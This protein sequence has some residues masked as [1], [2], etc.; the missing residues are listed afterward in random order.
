M[1]ITIKEYLADPAFFLKLSGGEH[2]I[3]VMD[4]S[5]VIAVLG[6]G[7]LPPVTEEERKAMEEI[8]NLPDQKDDGCRTTWFD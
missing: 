2:Q 1:R 4:G 8:D 6:W 3:Q 5:K 7:K